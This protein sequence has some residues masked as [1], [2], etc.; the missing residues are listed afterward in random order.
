MRWLPWSSDAFARA[1]DESRPVLLSIVTAWSESCLEME[2]TSYADASVV[3]AIN[4]RFVAIRVDADRR[5]DISD[6]YTLGGWPTTAF[7]DADGRIV[8][9]GTYISVE[10]MA[11]VLDR[12]SDAF[13]SRGDEI[14]ARPPA[15]PV[16]DT[17]GPA[18]D[19]TVDLAA[20]VFATFD[21]EHG[22]F[23]GAPKYPL[24]SPL[25]LA[26]EIHRSTEDRAMAR[27][28]ELTLDA[29]GWGELFDDV[30]GGFYRCAMQRDWQQ[31]RREKLLDVNASLLGIYAEASAAL[32]V[33]RFRERAADILRYVQTWLADQVDGGWFGSQRADPAYYVLP[34]DDRRASTAPAVD[35]MVYAASNARMTS[36]ALRAAELVDDTSLGEFAVKSLERVVLACY[37]PGEGIAHDL[38]REPGVRGLLD[39]QMSTAAALLDAHDGNRQ[40]RLRDDGGGAGA[41]FHPHDVGRGARRFLRPRVPAPAEL[42]GLMHD[43][44]KP[45]VPNCD[46]ARVLK[47]L[48]AAK[49]NHDFG[50][51]AEATLAAMAPRAAQQGPLA[52]RLPAGACAPDRLVSAK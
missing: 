20:T 47:R 29:I 44:L 52:A 30:D 46:A 28:V 7:L 3:E 10:R 17:G 50:A 34:P 35:G 36:A 45:F 51:Q 25:A 13:A 1:R 5:P 40:H 15:M 16:I 32:G 11:G 24:T 38:D 12:V 33:S 48:S 43:R 26:L 21:E 49:G 31:P 18:A 22:G 37:R 2:R 23:G 4:G 9:G 27:I 39:D 41:L 8:G 42:V 6:R 14:A 19:T